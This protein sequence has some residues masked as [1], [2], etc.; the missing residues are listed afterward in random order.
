MLSQSLTKHIVDSATLAS[1]VTALVGAE[2]DLV[3]ATGRTGEDWRRDWL[4]AIGAASLAG[5]PIPAVAPPGS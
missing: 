4:R 5:G 2:D 3:R 1:V